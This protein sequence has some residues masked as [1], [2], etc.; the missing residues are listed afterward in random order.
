MQ[1]SHVRK[2]PLLLLPLCFLVILMLLVSGAIVF[3]SAQ[4]RADSSTGTI[5]TH[6]VTGPQVPV[7]QKGSLT[8][9]C[10]SGE[11]LLSGGFAGDSF[12]G[13]VYVVESYP[14]AANTWTVTVDNTAAPSWVQMTVSVYCLQANYSIAATI[15]HAANSGSG[16]VAANCPTGSALVSGG[17]AGTTRL[18]V[19]APEGNGWQSDAANVYAVCATQSLTAAA[20]ASATFTTPTNTTSGGAI[21]TCGSGQLATGGGFSGIAAGGGTPVISSQATT[22]GWAVAA[23][24]SSSSQ[25]TVT[26][27]AVCVSSSSTGSTTPTSTPLPTANAHVNYQVVAQWQGGFT[28]NLT[29]TNTG[30]TAIKGWTLQFSFPGDQQITHGWNGTFSQSG[31]QVTITNMSY[32]GTIA[33]GQTINLGFGGTWQSSNTS[34]TTFTLNGA[35]TN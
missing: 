9:T 32:N 14:S 21:A 13:A 1:G 6:Q 10:N 18:T 29:I 28:V 19:S 22:T 2:K 31:Q 20:S 16:P 15:V 23:E 30:T 34:P 4:A 12:E 11:Q 8:V 27:W 33:P 24:G 5:V 25:A 26:V 3:F 35:T 17:Y 7:G